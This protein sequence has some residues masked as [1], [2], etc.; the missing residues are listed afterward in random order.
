M[1]TDIEWALSQGFPV[2]QVVPMV[3]RLMRQALPGSLHQTY[4][5][6]QLCELIS[7]SEPFRAARLAH[8]ILHEYPD[9]DRA[10]AALGLA[11]LMLGHYKKAEKCYRDALSI[12]PH[13]PWYAHNLGHLLDVVMN[14]PQESLRWLALAR[15]ALPHEPEIASSYAHALL[16]CG[17]L[18]RART[19]LLEALGGNH[20]QVDEQISS[21]TRFPTRRE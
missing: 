14:R 5:K 2:G 13:C 10:L 4:A 3:E 19:E 20:K 21:W 11:C 8:E 18:E 16:R 12:V 7:R 9:D 15:Q 17:Q 1:Y 6:R